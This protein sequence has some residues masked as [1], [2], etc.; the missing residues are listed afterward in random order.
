MALKLTEK[1]RMKADTTL[2]VS[3]L[4]KLIQPKRREAEAAAWRFRLAGS[5]TKAAAASAAASALAPCTPQE[6]GS[7]PRTSLTG[8]QPV[9]CVVGSCLPIG[10]SLKAV[11][12]QVA[13]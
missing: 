6:S 2:S 11:H 12:L 13:N 5:V 10:F 3:W 1:M 8:L 4:Q 7:K 9:A